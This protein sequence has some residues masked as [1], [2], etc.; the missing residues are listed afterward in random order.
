MEGKAFQRHLKRYILAPDHQFAATVPPEISRSCKDEVEALGLVSPRITEAGVEFTGG[1]DA[2]Y[3]A[4]LWLRTASRVMCRLPSFRT[5]AIEEL[6][7]KVAQIR[8]ELWLNPSIPLQVRAQLVHSRIEH[9]GQAAK[10]VREAVLKRMAASDIPSVSPADDTEWRNFSNSRRQ[11]GEAK[12]KT[13]EEAEQRIQRILVHIIENRCLLSLDTSGT[14]LHQRGYRVHHAGAPIRE[15]LAAALLLK[16]GWQGDLPL[17]DGMAGSGTFPIEGALMAR[18]LPPGLRRPFLFQTWPSFREKT[19]SYLVR[20]AMENSL[21]RAPRPIIGIDINR[22]AIGTSSE[23]ARRAGVAEDITWETMD[24]F[25]FRPR[26]HS[27]PPG[28]L[29]LNPPYG[30]RLEVEADRFYPEIGKH[31]QAHY[32]GWKVIILAP[33]RSHAARMNIRSLRFLKIVHG[34][35]PIVAAMGRIL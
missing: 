23:N 13:I 5:G 22:E 1:I 29:V 2:C 10:T 27:I 28:L 7:Q 34:G 14:H 26:N 6:F 30:L 32:R 25:D 9:E 35:L 3:E 20:K 15:T 16:S 4:N 19:W 31:L 8:W 24:F 18:R 11:A 21:D 17:I 12:E 33:D